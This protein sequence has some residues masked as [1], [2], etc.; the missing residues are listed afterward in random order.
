MISFERK[1]KN[2]LNHVLTAH[3]FL[4]TF[5]TGS[6]CVT[7]DGLQLIVSLSSFSGLLVYRK[8]G[9]NVLTH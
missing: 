8:F 1:L 4:I 9:L 7:Q 5:K 3:F 2:L 6:L